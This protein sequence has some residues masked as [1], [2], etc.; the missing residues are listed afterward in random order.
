[1]DDELP[2]FIYLTTQVNIKNFP[3]QLHMIEDY[4]LFSKSIDKESKVLTNLFVIFCLILEWN[5]LCIS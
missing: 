4:L 2:L 3:V 1:M 5:K